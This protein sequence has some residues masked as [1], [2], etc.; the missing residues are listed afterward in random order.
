M[1]PLV[2]FLLPLPYVRCAY[3]RLPLLGL[4]IRLV[5]VGL[6]L[7]LPGCVVRVF[8]GLTTGPAAVVI[9]LEMGIPCRPMKSRASVGYVGFL[10]ATRV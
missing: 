7:L 3:I 4:H 2:T 9:G 10:P 5:L 8:V 1:F 6:T